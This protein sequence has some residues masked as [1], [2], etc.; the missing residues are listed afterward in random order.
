MWP[1]EPVG[2][3]LFYLKYRQYIIQM[4]YPGD[5]AFRFLASIDRKHR[6][7]LRKRA[8]TAS[9][10]PKPTEKAEAVRNNKESFGQMASGS[11]NICDINPSM[12]EAGK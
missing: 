9:L 3:P 2:Y 11:V 1:E 10:A 12:L 5:I 8:K 7:T 4:L 6:R